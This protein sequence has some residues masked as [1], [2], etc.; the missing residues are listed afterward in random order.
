MFTYPF[1]ESWGAIG[2]IPVY[3]RELQSSHSNKF[4]RT[5]ECQPL[6]TPELR[7]LNL[8]HQAFR[9]TL[10][11]LDEAGRV[12]LPKLSNDHG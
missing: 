1:F 12:F 3:F 11:D 5:P 4:F 2:S 6:G 7:F 10:K 9:A 8:P